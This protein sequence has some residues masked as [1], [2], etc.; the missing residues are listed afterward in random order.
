MSWQQTRDRNPRRQG[1]A[2]QADLL[3]RR[4]LAPHAG[5]GDHAPLRGTRTRRSGPVASRCRPTS[6]T[7]PARST[8]AARAP[9]VGPRPADRPRPLRPGPPHL[10]ARQAGVRRLRRRRDRSPCATPGL[11]PQAESLGAARRAGALALPATAASA[12]RDARQWAASASPHRTGAA[13]AAYEPRLRQAGHLPPLLLAAPGP[14]DAGHH[15]P[16]AS[17]SLAHGCGSGSLS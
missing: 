4:G 10:E 6:R 12:Q 16:Q 5:H 8:P 3:L 15:G 9:P 17:G 1:R 2:A 11:R 13:A 14:N 7:S